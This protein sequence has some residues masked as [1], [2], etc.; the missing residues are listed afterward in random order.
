MNPDR[1]AGIVSIATR[2]SGGGER[3]TL[4]QALAD[5]ERFFANCGSPIYVSSELLFRRDESQLTDSA[6]P[7]LQKL[8]T[9]MSLR[10]GTQV[11]LEGYADNTGTADHN[12]ALSGRRA[13]AV[14]AWL[15]SNTEVRSADIEAVGRGSES[16]IVT[17]PD[18]Y[19]LNR[20]VEISVICAAPA[21]T[22]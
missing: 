12:L 14:A 13:Q 3:M 22:P 5:P 11:R 19:Y 6:P 15:A 16:P 4:D 2:G 21:A 20:R 9:L 8:A 7:Q 1:N 10:P 17:D 18:L